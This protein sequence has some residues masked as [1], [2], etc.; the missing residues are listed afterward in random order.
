MHTVLKCSLFSGLYGFLVD[1]AL[2][3]ES[4]Q[5]KV[6]AIKALPTYFLSF[7]QNLTN[8][9]SVTIDIEPRKQ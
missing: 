6:K 8:L 3:N 5:I 9:D 7:K 2:V 4:I 1:C